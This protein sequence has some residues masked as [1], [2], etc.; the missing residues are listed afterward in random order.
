MPNHTNLIEMLP[1][2]VVNRAIARANYDAAEASVDRIVR[3]LAWLREC[4]SVAMYTAASMAIA[5][6]AGMALS[7]FI[8]T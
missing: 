6:G 8:P 2:S 1:I 4:G 7:S 3:A 5:V